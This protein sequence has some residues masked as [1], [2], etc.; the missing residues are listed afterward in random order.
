MYKKILFLII[1]L[2]TISVFAANFPADSSF[3]YQGELLDNGS[4]A[5][6]T[7]DF[8]VVLL[9]GIGQ[10]VGI[11]SQHDAVEVTHGLFNLD[12]SFDLDLFDGYE[13]YF[14]EIS[15]RKTSLLGADY[16]TLSPV[17]QLQAVPLA[18]NLTNG[19]AVAGQ[20]LTFNGFQ[21]SPANAPQSPWNVNNSDEV[22]F[23]TANV[24]V[25]TNNPVYP[26]HVKSNDIEPVNIDGGSN[27]FVSFSENGTRR[28]YIGSYQTPSGSIT[29]E[30]FEIGTI[31]G[32][33]GN[34]HIV[35]GFNQPRITIDKDG[36]VGIGNT[37]PASD[38][39]IDGTTDGEILR[40]RVDNSTKFMVDDNGGTSIGAFETP[41]DNGLYVE[42]NVKQSEN[43]IGL[44]KYMAILYCG[45]TGSG[46]HRSYNG[47]S[48]AGNVTATN[49]SAIG[50]CIVTFPTNINFG[51]WMAFAL[52][53]DG[54]TA[55]GV[56]C[57]IG[58]VNNQLKCFRFHSS[59]G[60]GV[61][62]S[63]HLFVY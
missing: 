19:N 16:I 8:Q 47:T 18:T 13:D 23:D 53:V 40:V 38:L 56:N 43:S 48:V 59:S 32:S 41:P 35:T 25:G 60:S 58:P 50:E 52:R 39:M 27:M 3:S 51:Y 15:V 31:L 28:G 61:N 37:N 54:N 24:G 36:E 29:D 22:Y 26:L 30:D 46:V 42:G 62:G 11:T 6:D 10:Q 14:L 9:D 12:V 63:I 55:K 34:M 5:N 57:N 20:V 49:G 17:Q 21:W 4:P 44:M 7:Y 1:L 2:N 45:T 33:T